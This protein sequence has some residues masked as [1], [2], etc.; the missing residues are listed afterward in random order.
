MNNMET[1]DA[2]QA[3]AVVRFLATFTSEDETRPSLHR[4]DVSEDGKMLVATDGCRLVRL[5][6]KVPLEADGVG[7]ALDLDRT[8][9]F[10]KAGLRPV[11]DAHKA[12]FP[13]SWPQVVPVRYAAKGA[14]PIAAAFDAYLVGESMSAVGLLARAFLGRGEQVDVRVQAGADAHAPMRI[15]YG[16]PFFD[17]TVVIM[18]MRMRDAYMDGEPVPKTDAAEA[19]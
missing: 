12:P 6:L 17:A 11:R 14:A 13:D 2:K 4:A 1:M 18:P 15:D 9:K 19:A 10:L 8:M 3:A 16:C 7:R 5:V